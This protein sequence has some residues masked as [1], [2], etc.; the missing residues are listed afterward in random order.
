MTRPA[1]FA[2]SRPVQLLRDPMH[3]KGSSKGGPGTGVTPRTDVKK[4][5]P[6]HFEARAKQLAKVREEL[7]FDP[8]DAVCLLKGNGKGSL[9]NTA[10]ANL[11]QGLEDV[12]EQAGNVVE[13][14][15]NAVSGAIGSLFGSSGASVTEAKGNTSSG[16]ST[17]IQ[18]S[19]RPGSSSGSGSTSI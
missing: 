15:W 12:A 14:V 10:G 4:R 18:A 3:I 16:R 17:T 7:R 19:A 8:L 11:N 6:N 9:V 1:R 13:D 5:A 2:S